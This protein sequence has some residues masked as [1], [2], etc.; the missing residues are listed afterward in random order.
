MVK[1]PQIIQSSSWAPA[2]SE[3]VLPIDVAQ[4]LTEKWWNEHIPLKG[5]LGVDI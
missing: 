1:G 3:K 4:K 2:L 5:G